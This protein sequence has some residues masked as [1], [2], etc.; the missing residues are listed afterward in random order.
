M[1]V[2]DAGGA[3]V[4]RRLCSVSA[5]VKSRTV[6]SRLRLCDADS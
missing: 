2:L 6:F 1:L 3:A 5:L 4:G